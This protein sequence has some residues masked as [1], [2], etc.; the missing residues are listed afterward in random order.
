MKHGR[1]FLLVVLLAFF[2][3]ACGSDGLYRV[4]LVTNDEHV[5]DQNLAGDLILIGGS[6]TLPAGIT[7]DGSAH[8][9]SGSLNLDGKITGDVSFL[10]GDLTLGP[11]ARIGG[12]LNLGGGSYHPSP[13]AVI[14]GRVNTGTGISLPD[15]PEQA[16][17]NIWDL[18]LRTL[19]NG[20]LLGLLA[21]L[22]VRYTP[23][24]VERVGEA[25]TRH[26]LVSAAVGL[27]VGVVGISLLV[28]M[29]YT[30]L[31]IPVTL[32]GIFV[33]GLGVLY[34]WIGLGVSAG[35]F[36]VRFLKR[37]LKASTVAFYGMLVFMFG[38]EL[39]SLIP[40]IG[41]LLGIA[42]AVI[43]LG[44]VSLTRFGLRRFIPAEPENLS[45]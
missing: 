29:A 44:A 14:Q 17:P 40:T 15:L 10:N 2:L 5:F 30:I 23:K 9:F 37:P 13:A 24:A 20:T 22:L 6:A 21:I 39:L 32:L 41:S 45:T 12:D 11:T 4:S 28:T 27:L 36:A 43:G 34:G 19:I 42:V 3:S 35:R 25:A 1:L 7:L 18:L 26:S 33:L 31:L 38:L 16:A 8:I